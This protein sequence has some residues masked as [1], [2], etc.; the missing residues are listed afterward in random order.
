MPA[1]SFI[2]KACVTGYGEH[3]I[4]NALKVDMGEVETMAHYKASNHFQPGVDFILDIG[5][6]DMKAMT[7]KD[8]GALVHSVERSLLVRVWLV[9]RG[10]R[11]IDEI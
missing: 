7:I 5:G 2:G 1:D 10:V 8:G 6:Q 4:K 9:Y 11:S 3:L